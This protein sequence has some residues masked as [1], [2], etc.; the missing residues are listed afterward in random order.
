MFGGC[1]LV[2]GIQKEYPKECSTLT[3]RM[4]ASFVCCAFGLRFGN[5]ATVVEAA[6]AEQQQVVRIVWQ[7]DHAFALAR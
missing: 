4:M 1:E 2:L 7:Q 6:K 5:V 3:I